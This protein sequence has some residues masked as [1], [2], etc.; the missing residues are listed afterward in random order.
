M[1]R[2]LIALLF[3]IVSFAYATISS[4]TYWEVRSAGSNTNGGGFTLSGSGTDYSQNDNK[5]AAACSNCGSST[6][7]LSTTDAVA[8]GTTTITSATANF[9]SA[10]VDNVVYFQGGTGAIA[11]QWRRVTAFT[12]STTITID[13]TIAA[14][15]GMT[16]NIGGA[17]ATPQQLNTSMINNNVAYVK[18]ATYTVAAKFTYNFCSNGATATSRI[19]GYTTSR[20]DNG[21]FTLQASASLGDR[22]LDVSCELYLKNVQFDCNSK[23]STDGV[24]FQ[25]NAYSTLE[26]IKVIGAC[27]SGVIY[28]QAWNF[29]INC[30]VVGPT[31]RGF[32]LNNE[33]AMCFGCSVHDS[34]TNN[35]QGFSLNFNS[36]TCIFCIV[37]NFTGT[38]ADCF[39][40]VGENSKII[41]SVAY[42]CSRDGVRL[43]LNAGTMQIKNF[44][45]VSN[46]GWGINIS[47]GGMPAGLEDYNAFYNNTSGTVNGV[48]AGAHD[49]TLT[50]DPFTNVAGGDFSLNNTSGAGAALRGVGL[51]GIMNYGG[52]GYM[53][54]GPLQAQP[55]SGGGAFGFV[56]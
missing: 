6:V 16:M 50:G 41:N 8:N 35:A 48:T 29:C 33:G 44:V 32:Y 55:S 25:G 14:S 17:L 9:S 20:G 49:V 37:Y 43:G 13:A 27:S 31:V 47:A 54:I 30:E 28:N 1:Q 7:N 40:S 15:T 12:N 24:Q 46:G 11:A 19:E 4:N 53:D 38:T 42:G 5:N 22:I 2:K 23:A 10:L 34:A 56:Q 52:T 45:A 51:F 26:N 18:G 21:K 36:S 3:T 39:V